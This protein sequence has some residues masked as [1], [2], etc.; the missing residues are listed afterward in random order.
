MIPRFLDLSKLS[1]SCAMLKIEAPLHLYEGNASP[2]QIIPFF[3]SWIFFLL[4]YPALTISNLF[5]FSLWT[6]P[7]ASEHL[8]FLIPNEILPCNN[9]QI[10][11]W[12]LY[13]NVLIQ[14]NIYDIYFPYG[15]MILPKSYYFFQSMW[16]DTLY[17]LL[18]SI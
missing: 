10:F 5:L 12:F 15:N 6:L 8:S 11:C 16:T 3:L 17:L 1:I 13:C 18:E 2:T 7:A 14:R 9:G 4:Y